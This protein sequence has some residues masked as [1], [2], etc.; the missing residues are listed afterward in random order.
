MTTATQRFLQSTGKPILEVASSAVADPLPDSGR[1]AHSALRIPI[2]ATSE[3]TSNVKTETQLCNEL[4]GTPLTI[5]DEIVM[6]HCYN[7][8]AVDRTPRD[9]RRSTL[10]LGEVFVLCIGYFR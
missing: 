4:C 7:L 3:C 10:P 5:W 8:S 2:P 9:L 1:T 6:T